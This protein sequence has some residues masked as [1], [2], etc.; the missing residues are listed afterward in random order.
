LPIMRS[1]V[2][3]VVRRSSKMVDASTCGAKLANM[4]S[5]ST[6]WFIYRDIDATCVLEKWEMP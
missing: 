3:N 1:G 5:V 2:P 4:S 6:A